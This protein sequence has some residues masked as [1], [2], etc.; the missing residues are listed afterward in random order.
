MISVERVKQYVDLLDGG[1]NK[2]NGIYDNLSTVPKCIPV[3]NFENVYLRYRPNSPYALNGISLHVSQGE[4]VAIVGRTGAGKS[5]LLGALLGLVP[6]ENGRVKINGIPVENMS[7]TSVKSL[8]ACIPQEP[9]V[10]S[11]SVRFNL[12]PYGTKD[13]EFLLHCLHKAQLDKKIKVIADGGNLLNAN[14]GDRGSKLSLGERQLLC[15]ARALSST[16]AVLLCADEPTASVDTETES[17][18]VKALCD[19]TNFGQLQQRALIMIA[20][21]LQNVLN[22]SFDRIIVVDRGVVVETGTQSELLS[23][24]DSALARLVFAAASDIADEDMTKSITIENDDQTKLQSAN[25]DIRNDDVRF[26]IST[27]YEDSDS[28][29]VAGF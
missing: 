29:E 18:V 8:I 9:I 4:R 16:T 1:S 15:V 14:V 6:V 20:H 28:S 3:V 17:R 22:G 2:G 27:T 10:F 26:V 5:S 25:T 21:R 11:G 19:G 13:D 12:D 23:N 24:P 7:S